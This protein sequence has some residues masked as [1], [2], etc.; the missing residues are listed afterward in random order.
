MR[1]DKFLKQTKLVKRRVM[2]KAMADVGRILKDGRPLK[3]SYEVK[4]GDELELRFFSK[5]LVIR[6]TEEFEVEVLSSSKE[7]L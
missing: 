2:A 5:R 4:P 3:P 6:V 1:L 7:G